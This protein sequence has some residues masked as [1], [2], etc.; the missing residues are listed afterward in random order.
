MKRKKCLKDNIKSMISDNDRLNFFFNDCKNTNAGTKT[1]F[2]EYG[3][4][5]GLEYIDS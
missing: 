3:E 4:I 1:S 5:N 2:N